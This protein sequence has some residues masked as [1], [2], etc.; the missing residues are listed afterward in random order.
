MKYKLE[1]SILLEFP[2]VLGPPSLPIAQTPMFLGLDSGT[3]STKVYQHATIS[4]GSGFKYAT[5]PS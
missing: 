2:N 3:V 4:P 5:Q 1:I